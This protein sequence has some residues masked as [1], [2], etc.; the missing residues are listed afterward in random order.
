MHFNSIEIANQLDSASIRIRSILS[1]YR[2]SSGCFII[3]VVVVISEFYCSTSTF[4]IVPFIFFPSSK[5]CSHRVFFLSSSSCLSS[6]PISPFRS[7]HIMFRPKCNIH[8]D[9]ILCN[10]SISFCYLLNI[11]QQINLV[12]CP[13]HKNLFPMYSHPGSIVG[14]TPHDLYNKYNFQRVL[15]RNHG[16]FHY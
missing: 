9:K 7:V 4:P 14:Y 3:A 8:S 11:P 1:I 15:A 10:R 12:V 2:K 16:I 6:F 5:N 13:K